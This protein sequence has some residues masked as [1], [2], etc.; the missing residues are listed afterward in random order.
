[1]IENAFK[2][3]SQLYMAAQPKCLSPTVEVVV[4]LSLKRT[5]VFLTINTIKPD[6]VERS[7]AFTS[8]SY[9]LHKNS[10]YK[11]SIFPPLFYS[12]T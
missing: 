4:S 11:Y 9:C 1:M 12:I 6:T 3:P 2:W 5:K 10:G 7:T 8:L